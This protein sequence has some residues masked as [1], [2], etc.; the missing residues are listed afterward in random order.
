MATMS[1]PNGSFRFRVELDGIEV[2]GFSEV[3]G[4][5]AET[6]YEEYFEG[7]LNSHPHRFAKRTKYPPLVLKR[8][9]TDAWE[10]WEWYEDV[11]NGK[12]VRKTGAIAMVD[13]AGNEL[14][15]WDF[16][17]AY[18]VKWHGPDFNASQS[19]VAIET[20]ELVHDGWKKGQKK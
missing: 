16:S 14:R 5:Q 2:A 4:L 6:E 8:G 17:G 18:P 10:L 3:S 15:R 7:G 19:A 13:L 11:I 9:V 12:I 1:R 20:L